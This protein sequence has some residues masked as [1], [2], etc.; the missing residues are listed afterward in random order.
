MQ[1]GGFCI[2]MDPNT[3]EILAWANSPTYDLNDPW[4]VTD[5]VL[6]QYLA[7]IG[8]GRTPRRRPP[9]GPGRGGLPARRPA[10][11]PSAAETSALPQWR[12]KAINDTYEPGST[13]K[14]IVLAAALEEGVVTENGHFYCSGYV[15]VRLTSTIRCSKKAPGHGDQTLAQA[16]A[17]SCNPAF[18]TIG[19]ALGAEKFY[20]YLEDF[21]FLEKT[22]IDMQGEMDTSSPDLAPGG[23]H[24]HTA[25]PS[26]P[27]HPSA[28][29]S[30]SPPSSSSPRPPPSSTA[31]T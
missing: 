20:D 21:G 13:F 6:N 11:R 15:M 8:A 26:W 29:G 12:N 19:Q 7:D 17:N 4:V 3:G 2:A 25:S 22:G 28:S 24:G 10:T 30:R 1:D 5:P 18:V 31:A 9:E 16:V 27:P 14:S 23:L